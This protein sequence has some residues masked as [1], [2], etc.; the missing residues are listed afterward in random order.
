MVKDRTREE[1]T[2]TTTRLRFRTQGSTK[3][4]L[5]K[6]MSRTGGGGDGGPDTVPQLLH[7]SSSDSKLISRIA[8]KLTPTESAAA[9][10][11]K[12]ERRKNPSEGVILR[13]TKQPTGKPGSNNPAT[14]PRRLHAHVDNE[15]QHAATT[16][17]KKEIKF[18]DATLSGSVTT[19]AADKKHTDHREEKNNNLQKLMIESSIQENG[20]V[21][22]RLNLPTALTALP[23]NLVVAENISGRKSS[24]VN[25][26]GTE[27][28]ESNVMQKPGVRITEGE[29][30][31][32]SEDTTDSSHA[33]S[34]SQITSS[35]CQKL[36]QSE[37]SPYEGGCFVLR[38][39]Q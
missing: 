39:L 27:E 10:S 4:D 14:K 38:F 6:G 26:R 13:S 34:S 23:E 18:Q 11:K 19:T 16:S 17:P 9:M 12:A 5:L 8:K 31:D 7:R 3:Q 29:A 15:T 37:V 33:S 24:R 1:T 32:H 30:V 28:L 35:N 25:V 36:L 2:Q 21:E 22:S 20:T